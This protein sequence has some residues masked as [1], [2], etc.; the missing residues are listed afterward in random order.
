MALEMGELVN[1]I[2]ISI[3]LT[4]F[5][6]SMIIQ[7]P[8]LKYFPAVTCVWLTFIFTNIEGLP[9][10]STNLADLFNLFEHTFIMLSGVCFM[11]GVLY[12]YYSGFVKSKLQSMA[13]GEK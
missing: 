13:R 11:L 4:I 3:G 10:I 7:R 1:L 2:M 9:G 12:E 6:V 5:I 8:L